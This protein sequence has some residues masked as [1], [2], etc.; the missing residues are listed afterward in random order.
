[1]N[2]PVQ[3]AMVSTGWAENTFMKALRSTASPHSM[4]TQP[5]AN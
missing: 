4:I 1:M 2:R 3:A 5:T